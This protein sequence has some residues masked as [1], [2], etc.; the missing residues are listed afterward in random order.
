[1]VVVAH[2]EIN[3]DLLLVFNGFVEMD[4]EGVVGLKESIAVDGAER[5]LSLKN[6]YFGIVA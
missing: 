4:G 1:M 5:G 3:P 6:L 2:L